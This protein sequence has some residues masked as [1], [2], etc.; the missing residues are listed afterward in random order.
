[1]EFQSNIEKTLTK[2]KQNNRDEAE[3]LYESIVILEKENECLKSELRN[4]K[5]IMQT[6]IT[7]E[8]KNHG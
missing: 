5:E 3:I 1:M 4:Q 6:L 2:A 7:D 8:E